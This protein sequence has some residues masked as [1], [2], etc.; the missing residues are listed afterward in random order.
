MFRRRETW[1]HASE[2]CLVRHLSQNCVQYSPSLRP[3]RIALPSE[4]EEPGQNIV[5]RETF[6]IYCFLSIIN[7]ARGPGKIV[8]IISQN[9]GK[10]PVWILGSSNWIRNRSGPGP[11]RPGVTAC[12]QTQLCGDQSGASWINSG[13]GEIKIRCTGVLWRGQIWPSS[14]DSTFYVYCPSCMQNTF[15]KKYDKWQNVMS[16]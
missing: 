10:Y 7:Q 2:L 5:Y 15:R 4:P 14:T 9:V 3:G 8:D 11:V 13:T 6:R 1:R 16:T 12:L